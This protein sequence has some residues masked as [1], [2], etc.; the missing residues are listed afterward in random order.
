MSSKNVLV[1]AFQVECRFLC[2]EEYYEIHAFLPGMCARSTFL[3]VLVRVA[4]VT[5]HL[6]QWLS[7]CSIHGL[8]SSSKI[9]CYGI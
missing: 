6:M 2:K 7:R 4:L 1:L 8:H 3:A 9:S 5:W